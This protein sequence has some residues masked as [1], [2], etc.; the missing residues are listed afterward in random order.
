MTSRRLRIVLKTLGAVGVIAF[1]VLIACTVWSPL[2]DHT[3]LLTSVALTAF[4]GVT[5]WVMGFAV[6]QTTPPPGGQR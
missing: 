5:C 2:G 4:V 6:G 1:L 3:H